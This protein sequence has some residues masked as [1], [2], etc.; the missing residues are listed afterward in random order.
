M[1]PTLFSL[2]AL[3]RSFHL[4]LILLVSCSAV[5]ASGSVDETFNPV[6]SAPLTSSTASGLLVQ[7]DGKTV[8]WG[9]DFAVDGQAKGKVLRLNVDGSLDNTFTFCSCL[10]S[11]NSVALQ[12]DGKLVVAGSL[13][14][15]AKLI[16]INTNG[17]N[18]PTFNNEIVGLNSSS[19]EFVLIQPDGKILATAYG[20][21]GQG[22]HAGYLTR[23]NS[24]GSA[25]GAFPKL[26]YDSGRSI[27]G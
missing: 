24:D 17:S 1:K 13:N 20:S 4:L 12:P 26:Y 5:F 25:D 3:T 22:Y 15:Q 18:D 16:R 23:F 9:A 21:L 19:S 8:I 14:S 11:V 7:P 6:A 10:P 2:P 27:Y